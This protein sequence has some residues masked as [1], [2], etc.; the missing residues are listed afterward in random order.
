[1]GKKRKEAKALEQSVRQNAEGE[2]AKP[3]KVK[4]VPPEKQVW[5]LR[6]V[7]RSRIEGE[8]SPTWPIDPRGYRSSPHYTPLYP[9]MAFV[10]ERREP[11]RIMARCWLCGRRTR[12]WK[13]LRRCLK[14]MVEYYDWRIE[15]LEDGVNNSVRKSVEEQ[16]EACKEVRRTAKR[17]RKVLKSRI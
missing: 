16:I 11:P 1:M 17:W 10:A 5:V 14:Y 6:W 9:G 4:E 3:T 7:C 15:L 2:V 8:K 13:H 12:S